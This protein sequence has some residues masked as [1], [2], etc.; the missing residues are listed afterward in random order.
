MVASCGRLEGDP[1][2]TRTQ[3]Y[4]SG[5]DRVAAMLNDLTARVEVLELRRQAPALAGRLEGL[6]LDSLGRAL[7]TH[8]LGRLPT[9]VTTTPRLWTNPASPPA[10][11][12]LAAVDETTETTF[13]V[14]CYDSAGNLITSQTGVPVWWTAG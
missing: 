11:L 8:G 1:M 9:W 6:D 12:A 2:T 3:T 7:I 5:T 14:T 13:R 10:V 4:A